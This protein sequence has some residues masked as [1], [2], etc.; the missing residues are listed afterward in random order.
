[1]NVATFIIGYITPEAVGPWLVFDATSLATK[2]WTVLTYPIVGGNPL[3]LLFTCYWLWIVGGS[4]ERSWS[5]RTFAAFFFIVSAVSAAGVW[6]GGQ[7]L[8]METGLAGLW[9][10]LA[11]LTVAW[12]L[13]NPGEIVLL[14]CILPI[15]T[16]YLMWVTI[17]LTWVGFR[18]PL[19]GL[20]GLWGIGATW[21]YMEHL[22]WGVSIAAPRRRVPKPASRSERSRTLNPLEWF[23]RWRRKR[24]FMRLWRNS[25][26]PE[27]GDDRFDK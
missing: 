26:L 2:P 13:I 24:K 22:R 8:R 12:C 15:K 17:V 5:S 20:F 3:C 14:F 18:H 19:L 11:S 10:P 9:L 6:V 4:L 25:G 16:Q 21:L 23:A 1:M 27:E 7:M